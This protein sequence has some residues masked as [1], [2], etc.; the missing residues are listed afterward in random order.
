MPNRE[1]VHM[2]DTPLKRLF[3]YAL[4]P[5]SAGCVRLQNVLDLAGW[6]AGLGT[7]DLVRMIN[8]GQR[9]TIKLP[10]PVP[11][12]FAYI[13]AWVTRDGTP[14]FRPDIYDKDQEGSGVAAYA[15][16]GQA[17]VRVTP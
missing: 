12:I 17:D 9:E 14:N 6:L 4:R 5:Y 10:E 11:V 1:I 13:S 2:H 3:N 16:W 15:P 7:G 8:Q